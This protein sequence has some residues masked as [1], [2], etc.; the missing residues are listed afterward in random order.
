MQ[1]IQKKV[2][3]YTLGCKLNYAETSTISRKF[4][5]EGYQRVDFNEPANIVVINTCSVTQ[6]AD[7]KC[8][9]AINKAS[10][11]SP[12][13]IV[14][15]IGCYSQLKPDEISRIKGV[16]LILGAKDKFNIINVLK[17]IEKSPNLQPS[18]Y[19]CDINFIDE[20]NPSYSLFDRTRSFLKIQDGCNYHCSFCTIPLARGA[21]RSNNIQ[22]TLT[23][24][25]K[26]AAEGI[27][28]VVITG[29]NI[30]DFGQSTNESFFELIQE[31]DKIEDIERFRISSIEPNL[32]TDEI[33]RFVAN[34]I[35]FVP[36]FHIPLQ[37][38]CNKI[39]QLMSR[40]YTSELFLDRVKTIKSV[41]PHACIGVDIIAGFPGENDEE[42][43]TT[44][45]FLENLDI[46]YLHVFS[47][48]ERKNTRAALLPEKIPQNTRNTRS[49]I[50]IALSEKKRKKFYSDNIGRIEIVLFESSHEGKLYGY[51]SNY[52]KI[53]SLGNKELINKTMRVK[54][55]DLLPS[56]NMSYICDEVMR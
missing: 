47:Y 8:R 29:V 24:A 21:S 9:Q 12:G 31:L 51:T 49:K 26:I 25:R 38:G 34:S 55:L 53:E 35:H 28:E 6:Q 19:R 15:I 3:F 5:E 23:A 17:N 18:V 20:F 7:K 46:S 27:K 30:G 22:K 39:L 48:S 11:I 14:V 2:S 50:L 1:N 32:L 44:Q 33:I 10:R 54:L 36:H 43:K 13:A 45:I 52:I 42:F 56:G 41:M 37:S 40:R 16:N 4:T